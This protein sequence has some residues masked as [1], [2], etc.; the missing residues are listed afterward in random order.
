MNLPLAPQ[1][2]MYPHSLFFQSQPPVSS[3]FMAESFPSHPS[4]PFHLS[5][6]LTAFSPLY[7]PAITGPVVPYQPGYATPR[8]NLGL[9]RQDA[10]RQ[11]AQRVNR[12]PYFNPAGNH[13]HVEINRIRD[14]IDVRTTVG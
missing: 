13:N 10:R 14:G 9:A 11:N 4:T 7:Q 6:N 1:V 8:A 5:T 3:S 2:G 12:S